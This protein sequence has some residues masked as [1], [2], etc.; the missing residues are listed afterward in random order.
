MAGRH[1]LLLGGFEEDIFVDLEL[2]GAALFQIDALG[3]PEAL[4]LMGLDLDL[5][6]LP[7]LGVFAIGKLGL[8]QIEDY[9]K[10]K[11]MPVAEAERWLGPYLQ[12]DPDS[13]LT[14]ICQ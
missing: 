1:E 14:G 11:G 2:T 6:E 8:D 4:K 10:R 13:E 5:P 12:Y 9:A 7:L 3:T